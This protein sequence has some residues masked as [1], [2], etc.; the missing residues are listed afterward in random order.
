MKSATSQIAAFLTNSRLSQ[1]ATRLIATLSLLLAMGQTNTVHAID[2]EVEFVSNSFFAQNNQAV[3]AINAAA[4][5]VGS[6]IT[7]TLASID[8]V[9]FVDTV[10]NT[11]A[12]LDWSY[13]F[14]DRFTNQPIG[15]FPNPVPNPNLASDTVRIFVDAQPLDG[16]TVGSGVPSG[17]GADIGASILGPG[18]LNAAAIQSVAGLADSEMSRG[19]GGALIGVLF[20]AG[21][22]LGGVDIDAIRFRTAFGGIT[23]DN[24]TN[25]NDQIDTA[26]QLEDFWHLDH[27]TA[28][29]PNKVDL[30]SIAV[31][32]IVTALGFGTSDAFE[33]RAQGLDWSGGEVIDLLGSGQN[34][35]DPQ[36]PGSVLSGTISTRISDGAAQEVALDPDIDAGVRQELTA[37]DLAFL[38]D[39]GFETIVP[40]SPANADFDDDSDVD[41][42]DFLVWQRGGSPNPLSA[43]DLALWQDQHDNAP[44][45]AIALTAVPEPNSAYLLATFVVAA[46]SRRKLMEF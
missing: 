44:A 22:T 33:A 3:A 31:S 9:S 25:D 8:Q 2:I 23:L 11:T 19:D 14:I 10:G 43:S 32:E 5:H 17:A 18:P 46:T 35:L 45:V 28:V 37:L 39:I 13:T 12:T 1:I 42:D 29:D 26:Q 27:T 7:S 6:A 20:D 41:G 30:F 40:A 36:S 15:N 21:E 24:D 16:S 34:V 4:E 38:R